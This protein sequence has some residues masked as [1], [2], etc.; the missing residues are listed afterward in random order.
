MTDLKLQMTS[1]TWLATDDGLPREIYILMSNYLKTSYYID[2]LH[3]PMIILTTQSLSSW[4]LEQS[5]RKHASVRFSSLLTH[6]QDDPWQSRLQLQ[7]IQLRTISGAGE[8]LI[9]CTVKSP[10]ST[11]QPCPSAWFVTR[12]NFSKQLPY[13]CLVVMVVGSFVTKTAGGSHCR[14]GALQKLQ[15]LSWLWITHNVDHFHHRL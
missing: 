15:L 4:I 12:G 2:K 5:F 10:L 14:V 6:W 3:Q 13:C 11:D 1:N 7:D 8:P 9:H